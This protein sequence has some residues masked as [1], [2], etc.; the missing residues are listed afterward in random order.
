MH[1]RPIPYAIINKDRPKGADK[2]LSKN[3]DIN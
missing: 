1:A 2:V 3:K